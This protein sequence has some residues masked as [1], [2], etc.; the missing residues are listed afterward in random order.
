MGNCQLCKSTLA[1]HMFQME[2]LLKRILLVRR[3]GGGGGGGGG[4]GDLCVMF[5]FYSHVL[6]FSV[7]VRFPTACDCDC[8]CGPVLQPYLE[9]K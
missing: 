9:R 5:H 1:D 6:F 2:N 3:G 4:R 7:Q 8:G